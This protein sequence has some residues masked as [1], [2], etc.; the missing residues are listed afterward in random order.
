LLGLR[1]IPPSLLGG[2]RWSTPFALADTEAKLGQA[3]LVVAR[4]PLGFDIDE[5]ADLEAF[6]LLLDQRRV[7]APRTSAALDGIDIPLPGTTFAS[8]H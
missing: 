2:I 4:L 7:Y 5:P 1:K 6:R 8:R 3:G